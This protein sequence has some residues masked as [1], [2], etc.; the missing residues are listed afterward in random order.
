MQ[1]AAGALCSVL[2]L[3]LEAAAQSQRIAFDVQLHSIR[4]ER[5]PAWFIPLP[6]NCFI[7][8]LL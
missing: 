7:V 4:A 3:Q 8:H 2:Q 6:C 5:R 1:T